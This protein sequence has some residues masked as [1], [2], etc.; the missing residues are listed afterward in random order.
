ME[1]DINKMKLCLICLDNDKWS[2]EERHAWGHT[3]RGIHFTK[4]VSWKPTKGHQLYETHLKM[5]RL[6]ELKDL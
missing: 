6:L 5:V 1:E 4:G 3:N 2:Y